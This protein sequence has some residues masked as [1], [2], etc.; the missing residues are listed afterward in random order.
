M[1]KEV[2]NLFLLVLVGKGEG[3]RGRSLMWGL[4][5]FPLS[6]NAG[7]SKVGI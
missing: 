4:F 3:S 2:E 5:V 6:G 1:R 7:Y